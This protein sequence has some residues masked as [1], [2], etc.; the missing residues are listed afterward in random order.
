MK[1]RRL[2]LVFSFSLAVFGQGDA[3]RQGLELFRQQKYEAALQQF[4]AARQGQ[5]PNA[6]LE[7]FIGITKTRLGQID[8][9]DKDY[10]TAIRLNPRLAD[11]HR[12]LAYNYIGKAQYGLAE[13]HL[14]AALAIE[15]TEPSVHY[16]LVILYLTTSRDNDLLLHIKP[17]EPMLIDDPNSALL[18]IRACLR[19]D[20]PAHAL[21]LTE[22]LEKNSRF[23]PEQESAVAELLNERQ[24]YAE[25]AVRYQRILDLQP[26][27]PQNK[28]NLALA[29]IK[30][31]QRKSALP[32]LASIVQE[33][34]GD[35]NLLASAA[36]AYESAG[37]NDLALDAYQKSIAA[38]PTNP[39]RYLDGTRLLIDLDRYDEALE[40]VKRGIALVPDDYPLVVRVGAIE[41]M[42]GN[43]AQARDAYQKAIAEHPSLALGYVALAQTYMKEG[44]DQEAL[45]I[46]AGARTSIPR[47][48]ALEYVYGLVSAQLDHQ[49]Q[50]MDA[51][52][53]AAELEPTVVEP[54]Y[55]LGLLY[56]KRQQW[57]DAQQEF[58]KAVHYDSHNAATF[59]QLSRAYQR[60]GDTAKAQE[61]AK[62]AS[63]LA[64]SQS[65][66]AIKKHE[67]RFGIPN[68]NE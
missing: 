14:K 12:N 62:Q 64:K 53:T 38:D 46:V 56:M 65:E 57:K 21:E 25:S 43:R 23:S 63:L 31:N 30:A 11:A 9:A 10:E 40:I 67:L 28:Y 3:L 2:A 27:S 17:A 60:L 35:A 6:Q 47:D 52:K 66:D 68:N 42:R 50:A 39:D 59:Y 49:Q 13:Q 32:L 55:Q 26:T 16:Y 19:A 8:A 29:L 61:M 4:Q 44:N 36:T 41:A 15:P 1:L 5:P 45:N 20:D 48:F 34:K 51:L 18:A 54:H 33:S 37:D 22:L 24:M 7:D 58:E